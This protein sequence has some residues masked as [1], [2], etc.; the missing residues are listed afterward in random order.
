MLM[1]LEQDRK[2]SIDKRLNEVN[3]PRSGIEVAALRKVVSSL[4]TR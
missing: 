3:M 4:A 2:L 1:V